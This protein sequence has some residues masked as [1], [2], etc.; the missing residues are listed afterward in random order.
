MLPEENLGSMGLEFHHVG[1]VVESI[2]ASAGHYSLLFG[3]EN[4]S[5]A[6]NIDSQKVKVC[7]VK[8]GPDS[9]IELVEPVGEDSQVYKLL[10]KRVSYY[11]IGYKVNDITLAVARLTE[12][13]YKPMDYFNSE[14]FNGKRCIFLFTP[15]AH[16]IELIEK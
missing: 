1:L 16:L 5:A 8:M 3:T 6:I 11:H 14:A 7:F 4:I 2:E 10:K 9:F 12:M 15:G 13:N